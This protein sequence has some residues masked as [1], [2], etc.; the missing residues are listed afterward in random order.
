MCCSQNLFNSTILQSFS[1]SSNGVQSTT[2]L[3]L[4]TFS[5]SSSFPSLFLLS[6]KQLT[7]TCF[8]G[9]HRRK[10][11]SSSCPPSCT[12]SAVASMEEEA[13]VEVTKGYTMTQ[14][15]DKMIEYFMNEKPKTKD[16]RKVLVFRDEWK[17]YKD[18]FFKRC[19]VRADAEKDVE[20]KRKLEALARKMKNIDD[21]IER[22]MELLKEIQDNP[23]DINAV[24]ARRRKDFTGEF[25]HHLTVLS[26]TYDSLEDRD[27]MSRL[28]AKCLSAVSTYDNVVDQLETLDVAQ[29]KFDDILDSA[30]LDLACEKVKSLAKTKELDS[31]L[32]LLI[33]K[34][35][36]AAK[37]STTMKNEVKDIMY[38]IYKTTQKCLKSIAPPEIKLLKHLLNIEDPEERFSVLATTFSPGSEHDAKDPDAFYTSPKE[39]HKWIKI[40]LDAH[41]MNKEETDMTEARQM[42]DPMVIQRLFILKET[43]EEEYMKKP[44]SGS[45]ESKSEEDTK[46]QVNANGDDNDDDDDE[47]I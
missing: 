7:A 42:S 41:R 17:K 47:Y 16:W 18:S 44:S 45:E 25:F 6:T 20:M 2:N 10:R 24:V 13:E 31:N 14:L 4:P 9:V 15:C 22:H 46:S 32:I 26:D 37:E 11:S 29:S 23:M 8:N 1:Y 36:A 39:L 28:G 30:S 3:L 27:S 21:E 19:Q 5:S 33:N 43:I 38:H 40:M 35:W 12:G 34:A